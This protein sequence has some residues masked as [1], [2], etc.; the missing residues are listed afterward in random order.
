MT[1]DNHIVDYVKRIDSIDSNN[2][3]AELN[4][5]LEE[6]K[7]IARESGVKVLLH[8]DIVLDANNEKN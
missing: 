5:V 4:K 1:S 3:K 2:N 7:K 8:G 6:C